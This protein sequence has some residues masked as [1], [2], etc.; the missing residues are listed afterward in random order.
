MV[1]H[2]ALV[3]SLDF[4]QPIDLLFIIDDTIFNGEKY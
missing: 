3:F 1:L 2:F 4:F